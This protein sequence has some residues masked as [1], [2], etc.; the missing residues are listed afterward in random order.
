V[1]VVVADGTLAR[2]MLR[3]STLLVRTLRDD[4]ADAEVTSHK[5]LVRAGYVRRTAPGVY[6]WLPLGKLLLDNVTRVVREE[7]L[8]IGAQEVLLPA[9][10]TP[11]VYEASGRLA[12]Y[13]DDMFRLADRRGTPYVLGPTHEE[14]FTVLVRDL[15]SSY[16][17]FPLFLFQVQ[18]KY[19]D[20][21]RPRAGVL[22]G[23]EFLM[24]DSYSFD[25]SDD[26]LAASYETHRAAYQRIFARLE[27]EYVPV[28]AMSGPMG[29]SKSEEFI[30]PAAAG[31]DTIVRCGSCGYAANVEAVETR[32]AT[33]VKAE[34]PAAEVIDTPDTATV[35]A[36]VDAVTAT[37]RR[38]D[39]TGV[40]KNVVLAVRRPGQDK[41]EVLVIG[42]PGDRE[43]D[44]KRVEAALY[45]AEVT[46]FDDFAAHP[47]LVP[48]Y[49]GPQV[50]AGLGIRYLVDPRVADG[51][52]WVTGAN[53]PGRHAVD[54]VC[55]RDFVP[56]GLIEAAAIRAG[57]A[58]PRC[59]AGLRIERGI[60]VGHVFQLGRRYTDLFEVDALGPDGTPQRVTMGSYGIGLTRVVGTLAEQHA[61]ERGLCWPASVAPC[62]VHVVAAGGADR[63]A[64]AV[65]LGEELS[66]AGLRVLVDDRAGLSAG[67]RFT[68]AELLGMPTIVVVGRRIADGLVEVR[69]RRTGETAEVPTAD[70][71]G[72]LT[73]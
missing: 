36:L 32:R 21:K 20:E 2:M 5:L 29:G 50:L 63:L 12:E 27:V 15:C 28:A 44:L 16:K 19:R 6:S 38:V 34:H 33:P 35:E 49:I 58:C 62:Q 30:A 72:R 10:L 4:P 61:D 64:A 39:A 11:E 7:M 68:D 31:E 37:G 17:D 57:D 47:G 45:P 51:S 60:E 41:P 59:E 55:G 52:A 67:V 3:M 14:M 13:G 46:M 42:V 18:T 22:R 23:R 43:V 1:P 53:Q 69:D 26:G 48:G 70:L 40:L 9:L 65:A 54:V 8:A 71:A 66:A 24:K 73:G 56:D 25:L